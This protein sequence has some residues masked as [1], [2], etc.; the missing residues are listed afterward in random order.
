MKSKTTRKLAM[1][2]VF[3]ALA[4]VGSMLSVP[5]ASSKCA[6]VQHMINILSAVLLRPGYSVGI[7]FVASLLRNV[8]GLGSF[9][10]FP[11]SMVGALCCGLVYK[12]TKKVFPTCFAEAFGTG[13]LGG[14]A[15]YPVAKYAMGVPDIGVFVYV[16]PFLI[17]TVAGS[18]LAFILVAALKKSGVTEFFEN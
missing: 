4:V 16:V 2:G 14:I 12:Y 1:A 8:L 13:I 10:A 9:L 11:G 6:P 18:V 3:T 7:A 15:A 17:S 5:I